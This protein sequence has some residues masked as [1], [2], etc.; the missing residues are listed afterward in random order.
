MTQAQS[1]VTVQLNPGTHYLCI[2]GASSNSPFCN[3]SHKGSQFQPI[4]LQLDT[5][6]TVEVT[7]SIRS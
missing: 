5:P 1:T 6:K 2:C 7:G 4:A 3:G